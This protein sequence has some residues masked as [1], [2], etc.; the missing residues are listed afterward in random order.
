VFGTSATFSFSASEPATFQCRLDGAAFTPC[1][2][3]VT[4]E[5][6]PT[7]THSF[8]V[9]AIDGSLNVDASPAQRTWTVL[10]PGSELIGNPGFEVDTSG[11][12][13]ET[14]ANTLSRVAGG[15]S[16]GWA[17]A[18]SNTLAGGNCG[19]ND[20]PSW[21]ST[22]EV[23]TYTGSLWARSDTPGLTLN[24]RMR[25]FASGVLQGSVTTSLALT[26]S[27]QQVAAVYTPVA[28]GQS[29]IDFEAFTANSPVGVCFQADDA[30]ITH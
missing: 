19:L 12:T 7:G 2:S 26:S 29:T 3:P 18:I 13:G 5:D 14:T 22:T 25:E 15:H 10:A 17:V 28:P 16:G 23:G 4:Y 30:S 1:T 6:L 24:L 9:V 11:W 27:W 21:V 20:T 8:Q